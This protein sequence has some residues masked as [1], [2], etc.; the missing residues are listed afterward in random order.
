MTR[1][2]VLGG[3]TAHRSRLGGNIPTWRI[4]TIGGAAA[5]GAF[6]TLIMATP[7]FIIGVV[8]VAAVWGMTV[9]T[10]RGSVLER[11]AGRRRWRERATLGTVKYV[12]FDAG[13]WEALAGQAGAKSR[14]V[15]ADA[16]LQAVW[17][18]E[19]PDGAS[20]MGWLNKRPRTPGI[21]WHA[22]VGEAP[23]LSV[24]FEVSGQIR[25]LESDAATNEAAQRWGRM[26]ANLGSQESLAK[27]VQTMTRVLPPD[28]ARHQAWI[29]ANL[30]QDIPPAVA[31][32]YDQLIS[33]CDVSTMVQR[34]FITVRWPLGAAFRRAAGR[35]GP[36]QVGW[37]KVMAQEIPAMATALG[38]AG[39]SWV[40]ALSATQVAAVMLHL[41]D[42]GRAIDHV[43]G[44]DPDQFGVASGDDYSAHVVTGT[45][46]ATGQAQQWWH[47]TAVI[48]ADAMATVPRSS[49][50]VT[51]L[52]SSSGAGDMRSLAFHTWV[53]PA[54]QARDAARKDQTRDAADRIS[55]SSSG[56]LLDDETELRLNAARRRAKNLQAGQQHAG[57][58]WVGYLT[59]TARSREELSDVCRRVAGTAARELG[60]ERLEWCDTYQGAASGGTWPIARGL[61]PPISRSRDKLLGGL[62]GHGAKEAL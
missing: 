11:A 32:S 57:V 4:L 45:D 39:H 50:W 17:Q 37:E 5:F 22:P 31:Q 24:A 55:R 36:G 54:E 21:A 25:G 20:G 30:D 60:I 62:S 44:V 14:A 59:V 28:S 7:G 34:H 46:P 38:S 33:Q 18:R 13:Q 43:A 2:S 52:L 19:T 27:C 3:E 16:A 53:V 51:P 42:P 40:R 35:Q 41:Q 48:R 10:P 1:T 47:R 12:P 23:Y 9:A 8:V 29:V 26:L 58:D 49:L 6:L 61:R 15:R 56:R